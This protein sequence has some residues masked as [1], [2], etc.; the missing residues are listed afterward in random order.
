MVNAISESKKQ[1]SAKNSILIASLI[2]S[3][4]SIVILNISLIFYEAPK[5]VYAQ[6]TQ[7]DRQ[8][9]FWENFLEVHPSYF[10]GWV[11]LANL[12]IIKQNKEAALESYY[13]AYKINPNS[14]ELILLRLK[15]GIK[16]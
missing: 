15:L 3:L 1:T 13:R 7:I 2:V 6:N 16:N 11:Q 10:S 14:E 5:V 4:T 12:E 8:I 9:D